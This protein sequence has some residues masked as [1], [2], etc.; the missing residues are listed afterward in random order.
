MIATAQPTSQ[1]STLKTSVGFAADSDLGRAALEAA[2][3][4]RAGL[5]G[6]QCRLALLMTAGLAGS[7]PI[8]GLKSLLGPAGTDVMEPRPLGGVALAAV[9]GQAHHRH[10]SLGHQVGVGLFPPPP[11]APGAP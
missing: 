2:E 10:L 9:L 4:A 6:S 8:P 11:D 5:G 3:S 7:D 1:T